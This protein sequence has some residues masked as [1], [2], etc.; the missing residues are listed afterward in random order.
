VVYEDC[1]ELLVGNT[2]DLLSF[3]TLDP[4]SHVRSEFLGDA[5]DSAVTLDIP[6]IDLKHTTFRGGPHLWV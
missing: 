3:K 6:S 2:K 1:R 4:S 5:D